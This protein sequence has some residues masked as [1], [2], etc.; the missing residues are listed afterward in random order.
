[1]RLVAVTLLVT[2]V[3]ATLITGMAHR[4]KDLNTQD[5]GS[6]QLQCSR[7]TLN[8]AESFIQLVGAVISIIQN[9]RY[10]GRSEG[11]VGMTKNEL[12]QDLYLQQKLEQAIHLKSQAKEIRKKC[13]N[14]M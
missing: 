7:Y 11:S 12:E 1:M 3:C 10:P 8:V 14:S 2:S 9:I 5:G 13:K 6:S 4:R